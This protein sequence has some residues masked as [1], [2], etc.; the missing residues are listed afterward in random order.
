MKLILKPTKRKILQNDINC[1]KKNCKEK[2][3]AILHK[4]YYCAWHYY[5]KNMAN[6]LK[7]K[8][9]KQ[10]KKQKELENEQV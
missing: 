10:L 8:K 3:T 2:A 7:H 4:R 9:E 1:Y 5:E 6:K